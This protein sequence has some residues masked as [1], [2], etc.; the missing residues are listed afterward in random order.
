MSFRSEYVGL[1]ILILCDLT[2]CL[3]A[4][5]MVSAETQTE[6]RCHLKSATFVLGDSSDESDVSDTESNVTTVEATE[7]L[8][9]QTQTEDVENQFRQL[10]KKQPSSPRPLL[11]CLAILKS[12]V[13]VSWIVAK[14][15]LMRSDYC[16]YID[17]ESIHFMYYSEIIIHSNIFIEVDHR[18]AVRYH[19]FM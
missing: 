6:R 16:S 7:F 10:V 14:C 15:L 18:V 2:E 17:N 12:D 8:S 1:I 11:E 5:E 3:N 19:D 9:V 4:L 13:S